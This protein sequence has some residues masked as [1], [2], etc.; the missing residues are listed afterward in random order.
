MRMAEWTTK[1]EKT[2]AYWYQAPGSKPDIVWIHGGMV[3]SLMP[4]TPER[5]E[6]TIHSGAMYY[7]PLDEPP[8][9]PEYI[10]TNDVSAIYVKGSN[11]WTKVWERKPLDNAGK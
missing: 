10:R 9:M 4:P 11:G 6:E 5:V 1:P 3:F 7:G 8:P 2:G